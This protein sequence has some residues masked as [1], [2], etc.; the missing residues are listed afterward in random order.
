MTA[1]FSFFFFSP[2]C[3]SNSV[4]SKWRHFESSIGGPVYFF[5]SKIRYIAVQSD[6][7]L[8]WSTLKEQNDCWYFLFFA[9]GRIDHGHHAGWAVTALNDAVAMNKAVAKTLQI[10][11]K[12]IYSIS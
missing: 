2:S 1:F 3:V 7:S 6:V 10:V 9:G 5:L 4:Q 12:S 11:N 8:C